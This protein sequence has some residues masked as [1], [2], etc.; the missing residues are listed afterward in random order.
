MLALRGGHW[1]EPRC[2][3]FARREEF[4]ALFPVWEEVGQFLT[5]ALESPN[6]KLLLPCGI[7]FRSCIVKL[8]PPLTKGPCCRS[9]PSG[10]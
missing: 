6:G 3:R 8:P 10:N 1:R 9:H 2:L 4:R 7:Y 5:F